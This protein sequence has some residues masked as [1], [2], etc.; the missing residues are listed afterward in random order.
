MFKI[1][2]I[3]H[4]RNFWDIIAESFRSYKQDGALNLSAAI[5]FYSILSII[6]FLFLMISLTGYILGSSEVVY[7]TSVSF[8][9]E[10]FPQIGTLVFDET[11][12]IMDK[13]EVLGWVGVL[14]LIWT[15]TL[16]F[17]SLE[18]ALNTIFKVKK[19]R[20]FFYSKLLTFTMIPLGCSIVIV[21]VLI[22]ALAKALEK[23]GSFVI[24]GID[25]YI[26]FTGN[27]LIRYAFPFFLTISIF[28]LIYKVVPNTKI[29]LKH[30]LV[31]GTLCALLWE[32]AKN[33]FAWYLS[34]NPN[35]GVVYGS[36]EAI[37]ILVLWV[38]YSSCIL[39]FCAEL[40]S[41]YYRRDV[42][43]LQKAFM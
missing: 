2:I 14:S 19:K 43:I 31:G 28:T 29:R 11:R 18:F 3:Y 17:T 13:S 7:R 16:V 9:K 12:R 8:T 25:L 24:Y 1:D 35:Y 37:I 40:V 26:F 34:R 41:A 23:T 6:P 21:S 22:T 38:F 32:G 15:A 30:C 27:I 20:N 36:L 42:T 33:L 39:L 4:F 5:A 10:I